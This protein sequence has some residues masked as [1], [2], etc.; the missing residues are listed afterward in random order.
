LLPP[1]LGGGLGG[2]S[3]IITREIELSRATLVTSGL[4]YNFLDD[5]LFFMVFNCNGM[6][7]GF[8]TK[9]LFY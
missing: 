3:V 8:F 7:S 5:I 9:I 2:V 6:I 1:P 4:M